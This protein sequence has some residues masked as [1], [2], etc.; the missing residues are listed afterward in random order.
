MHRSSIISYDNFSLPTWLKKRC[1]SRYLGFKQLYN[2]MHY[3]P[4]IF[5]L[6]LITVVVVRIAGRA[7]CCII[8]KAVSA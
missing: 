3:Q 8:I 1:Y 4:Q 5:T 6:S 7:G 2:D